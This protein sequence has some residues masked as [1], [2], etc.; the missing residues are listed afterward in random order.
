MTDHSMKPDE[1]SNLKQRYEKEL[2]EKGR[3]HQFIYPSAIYESWLQNIIES[4]QQELERLREL[5]VAYIKPFFMN[6]PMT[7]SE[8]MALKEMNELL[9]E[10]K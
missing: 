1:E 5:W 3:K 8:D 10:G 4:Q 9:K 2:L 6:K 7:S